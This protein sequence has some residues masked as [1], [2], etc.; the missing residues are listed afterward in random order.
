MAQFEDQRFRDPSVD[1]PNETEFI[2]PPSGGLV[3]PTGSPVRRG[4]A[5]FGLFAL[6]YATAMSIVMIVCM[7]VAGGF[8]SIPG[9]AAVGWGALVAFALLPVVAVIGAIASAAMAAQEK[10]Q[11]AAFFFV[12]AALLLAGHLWFALSLD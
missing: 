3:T 7:A 11:G 10:F 2:P 8:L 5:Y 4:F 9:V 6:A 12:S 1:P